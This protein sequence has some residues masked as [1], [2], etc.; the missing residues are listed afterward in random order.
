MKLSKDDRLL[1]DS[2]LNDLHYL[3][4]MHNSTW[5]EG[6]RKGIKRGRQEE[7]KAIARNLLK[8]GL[9]PKEAAE[10]TG[11]SEEEIQKLREE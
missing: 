5:G 4:S 3:A 9:T 7:R 6:H 2:F 1:Y 8:K 10:M 11:L